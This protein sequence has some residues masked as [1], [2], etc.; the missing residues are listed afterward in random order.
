MSIRDIAKK[1]DIA[2]IALFG[3]RARGD[4]RDDSD[5]DIAYLGNRGLSLEDEAR[6]AMDITE[7]LKSRVDL[8]D[9]R[10]SS[11]LLRYH[12]FKEGKPLYEKESGFF[13]EGFLRALRIYYETIPLYQAKRAM[14]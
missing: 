11:P 14:L 7:E 2:L 8:V 3:S 5:A 4:F 1:Y 13:T 9:I 12:V 10:K 6:L